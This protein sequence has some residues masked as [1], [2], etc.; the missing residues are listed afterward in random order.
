MGGVTKSNQN[1]ITSPNGNSL[2]VFVEG[3]TGVMKVKD[4][5]GNIQPLSDFVNPSELSPF[6]YGTNNS[7]QP[8]LGSNISTGAHSTIGGGS[9]NLNKSLLGVIAGGVLNRNANATVFNSAYNISVSGNC[10]L[11][12]GDKTEDFSNGDCFVSA[13]RI[14]GC[15]YSGII[16]NVSYDLGYTTL[17][18]SVP[19]NYTSYQNLIN[20]TTATNG[21]NFS[22][23]GGGFSNNALGDCA[24]IG[25]GKYNSGLGTFSFIGGGNTNTASSTYSSV[26]GG[27][28]NNASS[29][30]S[31]VIGGISNT[32][33]GNGSFIG[34]GN[35]N[36]AS[37][38][39]AVVGGG[40]CNSSTNNSSSVLGG[41]N[42][43]ASGSF[44]AIVGG[45]FNTASGNCSSVVGGVCNA[46]SGNCSSIVGGFRNSASSCYS[47]VGGGRYNLASG[48]SSF[49]GGGTC[50][51]ASGLSSSVVGGF[52]N[53][54]SGCYAFISGGRFNVSS[55]VYSSVIGGRQNI[56]CSGATVVTGLSNTA[57]GGASLIVGGISNQASGCFSSILGGCGIIASGNCSSVVGGKTNTASGGYAFVGGGCCNNASG[58]VSTIVGGFCNTASQQS[59]FVGGGQSNTVSSVISAIVG[60]AVNIV[61]GQL[62]FIGGGSNNCVTGTGSSIVGGYFNRSLAQGSFV[63][64]GQEN[65]ASGVRSA[66]LGGCYNNANTCACAMIVGSNITANRACTTFVNDLSVCSF[67]ACSGCA[68]GISTNGLLVPVS[69]VASFGS[70]YDTTSQTALGN[71]T[72]TAMNFNTTDV[73][74]GVSISATNQITVAQNGFYNI[75]FSAQLDRVA[76]TGV[77][78]VD[79]WLRK[80]GI[81]IAN[82]N[83]TVT[84]TGNSNQSKIVASWNLIAQINTGDNVQIMWN[85]PTTNI[86]II[87][88]AENLTIPHPATPSVIL[89]VIKI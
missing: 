25:G 50:N 44:S 49:V 23:I 9:A 18:S 78:E 58:S 2:A 60:G 7:I 76:G 32:S 75:Q 35:S 47:F 38:S 30:N 40:V 54:A 33:S 13:N 77:V 62:S 43:T 11:M 55:G 81:N 82:T 46:L 80:N 14:S 51:V 70:F 59:S 20:T 61:S 10:L 71:D 6:E 26:V 31:I 4:V 84:M 72:P 66:I 63:G 79:I 73:S 27:T 24:T 56:A 22:T 15:S 69:S 16:N 29:S 5:M 39:Y 36:V 67:N 41:R 85:T 3:E 34:S 12:Y 86:K 17:E 28:Q 48:I 53:I 37:G 83:T 19:F 74:N 52:C 89:T 45:C 8:K 21:C 87:Y 88:E 64:G 42:N 1:N 65:I 57:S 68:V